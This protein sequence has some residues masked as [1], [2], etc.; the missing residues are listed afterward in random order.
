MAGN[1]AGMACVTCGGR[2]FHRASCPMLL[3]KVRFVTAVL[4]VA[5]AVGLGVQALGGPVEVNL[6]LAFSLLLFGIAATIALSVEQRRTE[7]R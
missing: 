6:V 5:V 4:S 3:S 1:T 7:N 2:S